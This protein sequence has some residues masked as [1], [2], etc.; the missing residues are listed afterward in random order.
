MCI[1]SHCLSSGLSN[2]S[3][4]DP[5]A[6]EPVTLVY[7]P[8]RQVLRFRNNDTVNRRLKVLPLDSPS[9]SISGPQGASKLKALKN[10]KVI[11]APS[12]NE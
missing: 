6:Y 12:K 2:L 3:P 11:D 9:F 5:F 7:N 4:R 8:L 1:L 10:T